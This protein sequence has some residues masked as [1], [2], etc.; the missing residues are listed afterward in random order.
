MFVNILSESLIDNI[1]LSQSGKYLLGAGVIIL[2]D[3]LL[4]LLDLKPCCFCIRISAIA[5]QLCETAQ[6]IV[7]C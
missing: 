6:N 4:Q 3:T 7:Q 1:H 5:F 2:C